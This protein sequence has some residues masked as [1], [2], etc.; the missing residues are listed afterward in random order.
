MITQCKILMLTANSSLMDGINRHILNIAPE[1]NSLDGYE[2]AVCTVMP[3]GD[4]H[5]ALEERGVA[6][7]DLGYPNG[8]AFGVFKAFHKVIRQFIPD[9]IH[10]HVMAIMERMYLSYFCHGVRLVETIHGISDIKGSISLRDRIENT[11]IKCSPIRMA[12][13]C[14]I[15]EGV[16]QALSCNLKQAQINEVCYNPIAFHSLRHREHILHN[17]LSIPADTLII[18]TACRISYVKNPQAFTEVMSKVLES[19]P[20]A[21]AVV[22]GDG[23]K[24]IIKECKQIVKTYH[25]EDRFHWLGYQKNAPQLV[26]DLNCFIMTSRSEGLPTSLLECFACGTPVAMLE[27]NGGLKDIML[28]NDETCP[29]VMHSS[30]DDYEGLATQIVDL[31]TNSD[32]SDRLI[33]N[34]YR[35]GKQNFDIENVVGHLSS[36]YRKVFSA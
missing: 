8:H 29:I 31:L 5:Q 20:K 14:Y 17:V 6:A 15:S 19:V 26:K 34:A 21:H 11:I 3:Y 28:L 13:R 7:Y 33:E 32:K 23:D 10:I 12:A 1:L 2:V 35:I 4:F 30:V 18:G 16:R 36:I 9:I 27:G 24:N 25:V 22:M